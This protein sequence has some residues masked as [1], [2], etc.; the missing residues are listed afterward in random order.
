MLPGVV[1]KELAISVLSSDD[2]YLPKLITVSGGNSDSSQKELKR[3]NISRDTSGRV[4]LI[5]NV[6]M[7]YKYIQINFKGCH[8]DG[9][10]V[11]IRGLYLKGCR[12]VKMVTMVTYCYW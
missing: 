1:V 11:R 7:E 10:D 12:C 9:C 3:T 2:S 6:T 4:V 5:R 8:S